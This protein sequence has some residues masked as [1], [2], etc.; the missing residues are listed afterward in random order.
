MTRHEIR[1]VT[2]DESAASMTLKYEMRCSRCGS[3]MIVTL[4]PNELRAYGAK[5]VTDEWVKK[6]NDAFPEDCEEARR[7]NLTRQVMD[8]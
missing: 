7:L 8:E 2:R 4:R 3:S 1:I 5:Q 6:W